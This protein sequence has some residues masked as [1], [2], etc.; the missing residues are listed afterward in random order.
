MEPLAI[1]MRPKCLDEVIGQKHLIGKGKI[2]SNIC[3]NVTLIHHSDIFKAE[4]SKL[5]LAKEK[6]NIV[7]K[8]NESVKSFLKDDENLLKGITLK[9]GEK[10]MC[11]ACFICIGFTPATNILKK[12]HPAEITKANTTA[13]VFLKRHR[14]PSLLMNI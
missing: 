3:K 1:K 7:I 2:L 14:L 12:Q 13:T 9:S 11:K 8:T 10:V 4:K 6:K 5:A